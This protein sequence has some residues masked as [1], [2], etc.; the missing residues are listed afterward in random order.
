MNALIK[1]L[2]TAFLLSTLFALISCQT[3]PE[4]TSR[5]PFETPGE[6]KT[7]DQVSQAIMDTVSVLRSSDGETRR[8]IDDRDWLM[9]EINRRADTDQL[10]VSLIYDALRYRGWDDVTRRT[11]LTFFIGESMADDGKGAL[12]SLRIENRRELDYLL[13]Q[14][15]LLKDSPGW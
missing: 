12:N 3:V 10:L 14:S 4:D 11:F 5:M 13:N 15:L 1:R 7:A 9:D 2:T 8:D 6:E